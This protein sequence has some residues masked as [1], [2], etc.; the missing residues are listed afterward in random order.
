[1]A[2]KAWH[3][4]VTLDESGSELGDGLA[5]GLQ[6]R[7]ETIGFFA[8]GPKEGGDA[9]APDERDALESVARSLASLLD[10]LEIAELR[11]RL[12]FAGRPASV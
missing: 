12:G 10:A 2:F 9:Y 8:L 11:R 4:P 7:E 6:V 3:E 5:F 1:M